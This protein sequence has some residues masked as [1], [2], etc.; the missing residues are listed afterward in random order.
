MYVCLGSNMFF[1]VSVN[2]NFHSYAAYTDKESR[3]PVR[4]LDFTNRMSDYQSDE[5][6]NFFSEKTYS[7]LEVWIWISMQ[8]YLAMF[9]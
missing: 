1:F 9:H 7:R 4:K 5:S 8:I 2:N 6:C 3:E